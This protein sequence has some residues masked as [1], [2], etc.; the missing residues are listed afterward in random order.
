VPL[1][2]AGLEL[3]VLCVEDTDA[4]AEFSAG[5]L[6]TLMVIGQLASLAWGSRSVSGA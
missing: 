6:A 4:E 1:V 3:G 2:C 5:D